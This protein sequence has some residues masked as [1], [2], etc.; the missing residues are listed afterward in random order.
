MNTFNSIL[1]K[2]NIDA[3]ITKLTVCEKCDYHNGICENGDVISFCECNPE[4]FN[5]YS[6]YEFCC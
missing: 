4:N 3:K 6:N 1:Y 2:Q 5:S